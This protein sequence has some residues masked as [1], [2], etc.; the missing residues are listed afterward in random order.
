[1]FVDTQRIDNRN[2]PRQR[3]RDV[4]VTFGSR[5]FDA[6]ESN[7]TDLGIPRDRT[8][9]VTAAEAVLGWRHNNMSLSQFVEAAHDLIACR[10]C[11]PQ[12]RHQCRDTKDRAKRGESETTRAPKQAAD[13]FFKEVADAQFRILDDRTI[14]HLWREC[15]HDVC[16]IPSTMRT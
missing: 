3:T 4:N 7:K 14:A 13:H 12:C 5:C 10:L 11:K 9:G 16:N 8:R 15:C 2:R 1:M 6:I